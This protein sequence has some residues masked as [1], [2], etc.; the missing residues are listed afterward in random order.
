MTIGVG[1]GEGGWAELKTKIHSDVT[2]DTVR[3]FILYNSPKHLRDLFLTN[4]SDSDRPVFFM[5]VGSCFSAE[6][7][8]TV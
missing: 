8:C 4:R 1:E 6:I 3:N 2:R 5:F 7:S